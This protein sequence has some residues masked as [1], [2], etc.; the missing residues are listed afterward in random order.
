MGDTIPGFVVFIGGLVI[1]ALI[2]SVGFFIY[3]NQKE[4]S[5][6][7]VE[8]TN[9]INVQLQ[10]AEWTQYEGME[11]TGSEIINVI[12]RMK[13]SGTYVEVNGYKFCA[14][15]AGNN[16]TNDEFSKD[17]AAAKRRSAASEGSATYINPSTLYI[18]SVVREEESDAIV[19]IVFTKASDMSGGG[20]A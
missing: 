3:N 6:A 12:K 8:Q 18:G 7:V 15:D 2:V 4:T 16:K 1:A 14:D 11:V 13:D 17:L 19:G 5:N 9:R 10:E 20:G